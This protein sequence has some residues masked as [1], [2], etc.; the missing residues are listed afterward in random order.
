MGPAIATEIILNSTLKDDF[1]LIHFDTKLSREI[2]EIGKFSL[3]KLY[4]LPLQYIR[5]FYCIL[6][7]SPALVIV[8]ISQSTTGFIKDS[9]F[10][11]AANIFKKKILL[12]LRGS[13]IK[14]WLKNSGKLINKYFSFVMHNAD[15]VIVLG[16]KL[17]KLFDEYF[18]ANRIFVVP[19]GGDYIFP[20][21]VKAEN[22]LVITYLANLQ[23]SKGITD[24][25]DAIDLLKTKINENIKVNVIGNWS[26]KATKNY[27]ISK[28]LNAKLPINF[29]PS[30]DKAEKLNYLINSDIFVFPPKEPEGHPWVIVEA[31]AAGL[32]IISTDQ[33]AIT[34]SVI[35]GVNGFIVESN[36]PK[37][38]AKKLELLIEMPELR[39]R[40]GKESRRLYEANFT[41]EKMVV[42]LKETIFK[43]L[44]DGL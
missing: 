19:N 18:P 24:L 11:L 16:N 3:H 41:E 2:P 37:Q 20:A 17:R 33:G 14:N 38:I 5:F 25:V 15:S 44:N 21:R 1:N 32:P 28:A 23:P 10:I 7:Q 42:N 12:Q 39:E 9:I 43:V 30:V 8:P 4:D 29:L 35:D 34:E 22:N 40:M 13:N 6:N 27:C 36:N 31:M 26:D